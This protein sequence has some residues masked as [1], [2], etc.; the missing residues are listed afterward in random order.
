MLR[1]KGQSR[2]S[3]RRDVMGVGRGARSCPVAEVVVGEIREYVG[4]VTE[5]GEDGTR[6]LRGLG[7]G[8]EGVRGGQQAQDRPFDKLRMRAEPAEHAAR[9]DGVRRGARS[10]PVAKGVVDELGGG[11]SDP[12]GRY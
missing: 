7:E 12:G 9:C 3:M 10:C 2:R 5:G 6:R 1:M 11:E 8:G 4:L